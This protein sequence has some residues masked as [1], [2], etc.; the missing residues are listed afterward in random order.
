MVVVMMMMMV[1]VVVVV[2]V[3][4]MQVH[5]QDGRIP[6][7]SGTTDDGRICWASVVEKWIL[8]GS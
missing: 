7:S 4:G 6:V 8:G 5:M 3:H 1:V 2:M